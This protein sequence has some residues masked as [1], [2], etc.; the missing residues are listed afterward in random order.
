MG[1]AAWDIGQKATTLYFLVS[2]LSVALKA[3][4]E[5][6]GKKLKLWCDESVVTKTEESKCEEPGV[7]E[8]EE[9]K[10]EEPE[11]NETK[12]SKCE[13]PGVNKTVKQKWL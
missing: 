4:E 9:S 7:N 1:F 6:C 3:L 2:P 13:E 5:K 8:T 12:E 10:C 11:V